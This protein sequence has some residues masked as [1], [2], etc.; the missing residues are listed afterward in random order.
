MTKASRFPQQQTLNDY[1]RITPEERNKEI[2]KH[3]FDS[4]RMMAERS[5][6]DILSGA[7]LEP[8]EMIPQNGAYASPKLI[9]TA[10]PGETEESR[11]V[12]LIKKTSEI[13]NQAGVAQKTHKM[14]KVEEVI[15][16]AAANIAK[17]VS[18]NCVVSIEKKEED[19]KNPN[20]IDVKVVV[21]K[22]LKTTF[23]KVEYFTQM[24]KLVSGS[25]IPIKELLMEAINKKY[26]AKDDRVVCV[27]DESV[28]SGYKGLLFIFDVDKVFFNM[29]MFHLADK[30]N[31]EVL[32][33]VINV[34]LEIGT[35]GREGKPIGTAFVIGTSEEL[36]KYTRQLIINPFSSV[37]ENQRLVTDANLKETIKGF[38]QLD[39]VFIISPEGAVV[40]AG[41]HINIDMNEQDMIHLQGFGTRHRYC[42]AITRITEAI[43]IVVSE[44]G[45]TVR[46]FKKGELVMRLP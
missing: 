29:S 14:N 20:C 5:R 30:I 28:G 11:E 46:I 33:T 9:H 27:S 39:G 19:S 24:R 37:P 21:F 22:R 7:E 23:H 44:S 35:E 36:S 4:I 45:G 10:K 38:S 8:L 40:S 31:P 17:N 25:V 12:E 1:R 18:A 34:A 13:A 2:P 43:A 41:T 16:Q 42:A 3:V 26:I 6:S 32:E 15:G